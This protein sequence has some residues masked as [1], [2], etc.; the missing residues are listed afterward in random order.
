MFATEGVVVVLIV[1]VMFARDIVVTEVAMMF[2]QVHD[3]LRHMGPF[4]QF[5]GTCAVGRKGS[6]EQ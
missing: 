3:R 6:Q 1:M 5:Q 4:M 2:H